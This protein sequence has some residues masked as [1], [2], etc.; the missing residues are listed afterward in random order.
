VG[1]RIGTNGIFGV[2]AHEIGSF[3]AGS[4]T[5]PLTPGASTDTWALG[6]AL[7]T[8]ASLSSTPAQKPDAFAVHAYEV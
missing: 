2:A 1:G 7:A 3:K 5:Y 8:G 4:V 6:K